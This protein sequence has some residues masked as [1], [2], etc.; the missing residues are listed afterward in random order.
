MGL[1]STGV[2]KA[3]KGGGG[4]IDRNMNAIRRPDRL[5]GGGHWQDIDRLG[6]ESS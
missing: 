3:T 1:E 5:G 4:V 6:E 2:L